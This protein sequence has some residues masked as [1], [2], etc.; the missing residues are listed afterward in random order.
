MPLTFLAWLRLLPRWLRL[1]FAGLLSA[2]P[3]WFP[4]RL[5]LAV[6][7]SGGA[8]GGVPFARAGV[9]AWFRAAWCRP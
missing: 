7:V 3:G 8:G 5:P 4:G 9:V 2:C 6:R 1:V